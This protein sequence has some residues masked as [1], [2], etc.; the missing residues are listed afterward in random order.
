[1]RNIQFIA[2]R[3][4]AV[5]AFI[6][7]L[8]VISITTCTVKFLSD[9]DQFTD[10]LAQDLFKSLVKLDIKDSN[11]KGELKEIGA[12]IKVLRAR[13]ESIA[14]NE[15]TIKAIKLLEDNY[16]LMLKIDSEAAFQIAADTM[17]QQARQI[18]DL[19][20]KKKRGIK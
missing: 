14:K 18:M 17:L 4:R 1:M 20:I 16:R 9:Y 15:P 5:T 10:Q 3:N 11:Y 6:L 13:S 8:F 12:K 2:S 19:E 7:F